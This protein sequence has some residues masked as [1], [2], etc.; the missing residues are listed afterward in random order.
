MQQQNPLVVRTAAQ[1]TSSIGDRMGDMRIWLDR[2]KI[3]TSGFELV[4]LSVGNIAFD[5]QFSDA[6]H[7]ALFHAAFGSVAEA[8][9]STG[10]AANVLPLAQPLAR[11]RLF[12]RYRRAA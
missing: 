9:S 11:R 5:A 2:N 7:A 3:S 6:G 10:A 8:F 12:S 1:P 4:A